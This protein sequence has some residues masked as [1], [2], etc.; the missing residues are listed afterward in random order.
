MLAL[1]AA[2]SLYLVCA[3][4]PFWRDTDGF[5]EIASTFA[6][7]GIIHWLPGYCFLGRLIV[8]IGA[9]LGSLA[10]GRGIPYLSLGTPTL[11]NPGIYS[12]ILFQHLLLV[13]SLFYVVWK[14]AT[15][16][17]L[18]VVFCGFFASTPWLYVYAHC[19]GSEAFSNPL[20][21]LISGCGWD[22]LRQTD[23]RDAKVYFF[24]LCAANLT[25]QVNVLLGLILPLALFLL[26][27]A[28]VTHRD[29]RYRYWRRLW[30][31]LLAVI[32]S[33]VCSLLIQQLM[34]L[35]FRVPYRSTFGQT[36]EW[37]LEYLSGVPKD[38]RSAFLENISRQINDPLV[39][40]ALEDLNGSFDR[41]EK[42]RDMFLFYRIDELL[43]G[44]TDTQLRTWQTDLKLNAI[45]GAILRSRNPDF[46]GAVWS[47]LR[48]V[49]SF[50]QA[51]LAFS[52]FELTDVLKTQLDNPR[53]ARLRRIVSFQHEPGF[54][55]TRWRQMPYFQ[56]FGQ[57]PIKAL[58]AATVV[59]LI[60][61]VCASLLAKIRSLSS[62]FKDSS[63]RLGLP[64]VCY[65]IALLIGGGL[66]T[67]AT[68][69]STFL[70]A[71][72]YLP[73]YT[74]AQVSL[75]LAATVCVN[76]VGRR[77]E[78]VKTPSAALTES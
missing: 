11:N 37:R 17:I 61:T 62:F 41:G 7:K 22:Y 60:G 76:R 32:F 1:L 71:R 59:M 67:V 57:I 42:W 19:V 46:L 20:V 26:L 3:L 4:P 64:G 53:Y 52:P 24:L 15:G 25:R 18:R 65:S 73:V 10:Q 74:L 47:D 34:C 56:V 2:P 13:C 63:G 49:P 75:M 54:Y 14:I 58:I 21:L 35:I 36:F 28:N 16:P 8:I 77:K 40:E 39:T 27:S 23:R 30:P 44:L 12:L 9:V 38:R 51:D 70:G 45:A 78:V 72:F 50:T 29:L 5:N 55:Q 33:I 68:C 31:V 48:A 69:C 66:I 43:H 6:P